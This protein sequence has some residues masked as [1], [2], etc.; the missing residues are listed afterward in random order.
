MRD[1]SGKET[2]RQ[3]SEAGRQE[4]VQD[5][6]RGLSFNRKIWIDLFIDELDTKVIALRINTNKVRYLPTIL[7]R[8]Y[9]LKHSGVGQP[10]NSSN[11][12]ITFLLKKKHSS[13]C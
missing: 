2:S 5:D 12:L 3:G 10:I 9:L 1:D 6:H 11:P 8:Q 13:Y 7:W 4:A